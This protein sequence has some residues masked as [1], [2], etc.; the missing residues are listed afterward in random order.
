M[1]V[2]L[3]HNLSVW[4]AGAILCI[5][6]VVVH[7][8]TINTAYGN[9][10]RAVCYSA[11]LSV[12]LLCP[13][14]GSYYQYNMAWVWNS[15]TTSHMWQNIIIFLPLG[16]YW[17]L[18]IDSFWCIVILLILGVAI[19][20]LQLLVPGRV[21]DIMDIAGNGVGSIVGALIARATAHRRTT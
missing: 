11:V 14:T 16:Y 8:L 5:E 1:F 12:L 9:I 6:L 20:L 7:L 3:G 13:T 17:Y 15:Y 4:W 19:E 21:C 2:L 10:T 18:T